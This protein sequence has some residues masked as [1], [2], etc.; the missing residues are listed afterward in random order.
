MARNC[1]FAVAVHVCAV[2]TL[3]RDDPPA[4]SD[5]IA[6]SVNTN[7]V[8]VR[9]L[10]SALGKAGLVKSQRGTSGGSALA[11]EAAAITLLDISRAVDEDEGPP[12]PQQEPNPACPVGANIRPI[13]TDILDRAE[14]ARD[15]ELQRTTL[16][17]IAASIRARLAP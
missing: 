10:L 5:W 17:D 3:R 11:K 4:T 16:A 15:R 14:A 6:K 13:L 8:V 1:R 7:P 12:L 9:R 2:L